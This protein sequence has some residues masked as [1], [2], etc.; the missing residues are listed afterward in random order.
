MFTRRLFC[1]ALLCSANI[2]TA[3][4]FSRGNL[5]VLHPWLRAT[6]PGQ[7]AAALYLTLDNRGDAAETLTRI[8]TSTA[9]GA[10]VH[11]MSMQGDVMQMR[12][13]TSLAVPALSKVAMA[14]GDGYHIM[15]TGLRGPLKVGQKIT[16]QLR[17][18]HAGTI[19]VTAIVETQDHQP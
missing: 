7:P 13:V 5:H 9:S 6:A 10:A 8:T 15:L 11:T 2:A 1:L 3:H 12:E 17:F 19:P 4:E 16:L 14:P 18:K